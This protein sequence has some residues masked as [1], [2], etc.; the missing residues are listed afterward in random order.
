[1][2]EFIQNIALLI[3]NI[4]SFVIH[5]F[6]FLLELLTSIPR[7]LA[8]ITGVIAVLPPFVGG[9]ILVSVSVSVLLMIINH[10]GD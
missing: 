2:F 10:G 8:Y 6:T 7:A 1:M 5:A 3:A 9:V 4:I